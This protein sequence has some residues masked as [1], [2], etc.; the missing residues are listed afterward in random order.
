LE[1]GDEPCFGTPASSALKALVS[2]RKASPYRSGRSLDWLKS[3][4]P[5]APA[6]TRGRRELG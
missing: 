3:K 2:K 4:N 1:E 5:N 6:V